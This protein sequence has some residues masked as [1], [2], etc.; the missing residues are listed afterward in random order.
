MF[1]KESYVL[2]NVLFSSKEHELAISQL[3]HLEI[4]GQDENLMANTPL[5]GL[6]EIV[7]PQ[8]YLPYY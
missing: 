5:F 3:L 8:K 4:N 6:S 7:G 2:I 1:S